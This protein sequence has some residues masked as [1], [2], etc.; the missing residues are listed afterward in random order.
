MEIMSTLENPKLSVLTSTLHGRPNRSGLSK[1]DVFVCAEY[2]Q[3]HG[4]SRH[5]EAKDVPAELWGADLEACLTH[6][7][8]AF[9]VQEAKDDLKK[10]F[11]ELMNGPMAQPK[12]YEDEREITLNI[13]RG[14][15]LL[16][17]PYEDGDE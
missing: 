15:K 16:P 13:E 12:P 9:L 5:R 2:G 11:M 4:F 6:P 1:L 8:T 14:P 7:W 3:L 17:K 10:Q